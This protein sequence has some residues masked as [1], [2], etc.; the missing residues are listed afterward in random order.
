MRGPS[1]ERAEAL[2]PG[3]QATLQQKAMQL[4]GGPNSTPLVPGRGAVGGIFLS[5]RADVML[6]YCSSGQAVMRGIVN[7]TNVPL[8]PLLTVG[9]AYGVIV[10]IDQ[11]LAARFALF[12][13]PEQGQT[14][15]RQYGFDSIGLP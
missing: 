1:S 3:A 11:P 13:L 2:P 5:G 6:G 15:L 7:L 12:V 10:L 9:P 8:P 14:I 4:V